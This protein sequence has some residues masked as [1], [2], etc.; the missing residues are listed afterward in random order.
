MINL[1]EKQRKNEIR[2]FV[3]S[4]FEDLKQERDSLVDVVFPKLR[5]LCAEREIEFTEIDLRW[6]VTAKQAEQGKVIPI[7]LQQI[8]K[9]RPYFIGVLGH[10]YGWK[11]GPDELLKQENLAMEY[12]WLKSD[13][14]D[15]MSITEI[16]I[17]YGVLR[18]TEKDNIAFFYFRNDSPSKFCEKKGSPQEIKMENLKAA[19]RESKYSSKLFKSNEQLGHLILTDFKIYLDDNFP[20]K[21]LTL[22]EREQI[23]HAAFAM[24]RMNLYISVKD[25]FKAIDDHIFNLS[26]PLVITGDSGSGKSALLSNWLKHFQ[27]RYPNE[28]VFYHFVGGGGP[29][30][31]SHYNVM[32]RIMSELKSYFDLDIEIPLSNEKL[33]KVLP[34]LFGSIPH[35][36][37][38]V[39]VIDAL[40]QLEDKTNA[41]WLGWLP[42][43]IPD[44]IRIIVST[45]QDDTF[46]EVC[47][48]EYR[49][50]QVEKLENSE[51]KKLIVD[52]LNLFGK[53]LSKTE[54]DKIIGY[55]ESDSPLILRTILDEL[56][57]F[58]VHERL[59]E[60]I[61]Y[62]LNST[63]KRD[64]FN[65]VLVRFENVY[66]K[67]LV[68]EVLP[69]IWS[70]RRG[71]SEKE[72]LEIAKIPALN[73]AP[74]FYAIENHMVSRSGILDFFHDHFR[75]AVETRYLKSENDKRTI[76][77]KLVKYFGKDRL[78]NR[79]I[80]ELP[81]QLTKANEIGQLRN[82]VTDIEVFLRLYH[83]GGD[84]EKMELQNIFHRV[85]K[86]GSL[87][88]TIYQKFSEDKSD[89][90]QIKSDGVIEKYNEQIDVIIEGYFAM[91]HFA[92]SLADIPLA[93]NLL[94]KVLKL[95]EE[96]FTDEP[97]ITAEILHQLGIV[98]TLKKSE[99]AHW[100][101]ESAIKIFKKYPEKQ[102]ELS[103]CLGD[104]GALHLIRRNPTASKPLLKQ[105]L[106]IKQKFLGK[107][108][109][110]MLTTAL[111]LAKTYGVHDGDKAEKIFKH[112]I[113]IYERKLGPRH[114]KV[115]DCYS[116]LGNQ[117]FDETRF[118][119]AENVFNKALKIYENALGEEHSHYAA[120]VRKSLERL[121]V[122]LKADEKRISSDHDNLNAEKLGETFLI[123]MRRNQN[124]ECISLLNSGADVNYKEKNNGYTALMIGSDYENIEMVKH[125]L[126]VGADAN[127]K[128]DDG[129][130]AL[131]IASA[132]DNI[133]II[134]LLLSHGADVN[135]INEAYGT[136]ALMMAAEI[137]GLKTIQFLVK[138][139]ADF[140]QKSKS[141]GD[142]TLTYAAVFNHADI[143]D[144][145]LKAGADINAT[146]NAAVSSL[147]LAAINENEKMIGILLDSGVNVKAKDKN[148][149][150]AFDYAEFKKNKKIMK[151]LK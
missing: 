25:Y 59:Q 23:A 131:M 100:L 28:F 122:C 112:A 20:E 69:L 70:S 9:C 49:Q 121:Q 94:S 124:H 74:F 123:A 77:T 96:N 44:N 61:E 134:S 148:G 75:K 97:F 88:E 141:S 7:C 113:E 12:P 60:R 99:E 107:E 89:L 13:I 35:E 84:P 78:S 48:R 56:R 85:D 150:S 24:S 16:E 147:M 139:G 90:D 33:E 38:C 109:I 3:S 43:N 92:I 47:K 52:Y 14:K 46:D 86:E 53:E 110:K 51:K 40:N 37:R 145:L 81:Y 5:K 2:L 143:V 15:G 118:I 65:K 27:K 83:K 32:R 137:G 136:S 151:M 93:E 127:I 105:S 73:W 66:G 36:Q 68:K 19:I 8:E 58:G 115:G 138:N 4:T 125:L 57:I 128:C 144:F 101:F 6:G 133:E 26:K 146:D 117:Y 64:F 21:E 34:L 108:S 45:L 55:S 54:I 149:W 41:R 62:Y 71:L 42:K 104:F 106:E 116:G 31:S 63:S 132:K 17:Q 126:R 119:E 29:D 120:N 135:A 103:E 130:T 114:P 102:V 18:N 111:N 11:P 50:L 95:V 87:N 22:A 72:I 10:R 80:D 129:R 30:S 82:Y 91:G 76:R 1:N 140:N 142:T 98:H 79:A 39:I 67:D